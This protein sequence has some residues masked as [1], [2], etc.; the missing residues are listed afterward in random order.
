MPRARRGY[1]L[2]DGLAPLVIDAFDPEFPE[3]EAAY[4]GLGASRDRTLFCAVG[5]KTLDHGAQL[6]AL[7]PAAQQLRLVG[8]LDRALSSAKAIPHGKVHSDFTDLDGMLYGATHVGYYDAASTIEKPGSAPGFAPYPG[9]CFFALDRKG[10][11]EAISSIAQAPEGEGIITMTADPVRRRLHALTWPSALLLELDIDTRALRNFGAVQGAAENGSPQRGDWS[12]VCRSIGVDP[13]DGAV[14]WCTRDGAI[15]RRLGD[16]MSTH[17]RLPR[18]EMWRKVSWHPGVNAFYGITWESSALFRFDP[19][20]ARCEELGRLEAHDGDHRTATLAFLCDSTR[21]TIEYLA[22]SRG[23]RRN[24]T[25]PLAST[26]WHLR[27]DLRSG[28][29]ERRGPLVLPDGR[30]VTAA[31]SLLHHDGA[32]WSLASVEIRNDDRSPRAR[33][34]RDLRRATREF[35]ARGYA[36]EIQLIRIPVT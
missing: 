9:G 14:Y 28:D 23:I 21:N 1:L 11:S 6:Y 12:R 10:G 18:T 20:T 24:F 17:A 29:T 13:R 35:R 22:M 8:D 3:G 4:N 7:D 19:T 2:G 25:A 31:Q 26:V 27:H 34:I 30:F 5:S 36:E 16:A 32:L 33:H 15:H